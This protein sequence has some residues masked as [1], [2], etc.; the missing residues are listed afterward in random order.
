MT[1]QAEASR[2]AAAPPE[3]I[4]RVRRCPALTGD[5][6]SDTVLAMVI[7]EPDDPAMHWKNA[8]LSSRMRVALWLALEVG[9]GNRFEKQAMRDA[10]P[11]VEQ[12]DRRM[13][14]LRDIGWVILNYKD[15]PLL[16][17]NELL[18]ESIGD[19]IW[20]PDYRPESRRGVSA[21]DKRRVFDRDNNRCV[22][23]GIAAGEE[24]PDN[25]A[26]RARLTIGHLVPKGRRGWDDLDNLRT[27]CAMC[28]ETAR[29]TTDA[30]VDPD[31]LKARIQALPHRE[32]ATLARWVLANKRNFT[33]TERLWAQYRQLPAPQRDDL[34][35]FLADYLG[36]EDQ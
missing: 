27:E 29:H 36:E 35:T 4:F 22:V 7:D 12:L 2:H 6:G 33:E 32:R 24:Y 13:R 14:D 30:G 18:L 9:E 31:L 3:C 8:R 17:P 19:L 20:E 23:C 10:I 16:S 25:P 15:T 34:R 11:G 26:R 28:N 21:A 5:V 1:G